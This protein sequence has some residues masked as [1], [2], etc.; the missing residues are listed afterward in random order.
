M[1]SRGG[2]FLLFPVILEAT[3]GLEARERKGRRYTLIMAALCT[4]G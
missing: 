1:N 3:K 2:S 4:I